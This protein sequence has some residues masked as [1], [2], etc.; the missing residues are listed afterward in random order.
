MEPLIITIGVYLCVT[1]IYDYV[2]FSAKHRDTQ[3]QI[4]ALSA[5]VSTLRTKIG[6]LTDEIRTLAKK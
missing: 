4:T 3:Y 6:Y 2:A 1:N 5:E